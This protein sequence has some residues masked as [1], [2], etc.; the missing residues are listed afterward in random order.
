[1]EAASQM[2][3]NAAIGDVP[4]CDAIHFQSHFSF[5][6]ALRETFRKLHECEH[7]RRA[8]KFRSIAEPSLMKIKKG[9]AFV[10]GMS[11]PNAATIYSDAADTSIRFAF[12]SP[13]TT[14]DGGGTVQDPAS[15]AAGQV[16]RGATGAN[17]AFVMPFALPTLAL[18]ETVANATIFFTNANSN[19]QP[20]AT[21]LYGLGFRTSST[22][23]SGDFYAGALDTT[24][25]TLIQDTISPASIASTANG[26]ITTSAAALTN[27]IN[28]Q[29]AAGAVSGDFLFFRLNTDAL[30]DGQRLDIQL[31]NNSTV[32][33][34]PTL[35]F[36][37]VPV[38]EP[39]SA[40]LSALTLGAGL[41]VRRRN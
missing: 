12:T 39:S 26:G 34:R 2:I 17:S 19:S 30:T 25:A 7:E 15:T 35:T 10:H 36:D 28:A 13:T 23:L 18:G 11:L 3:V 4:Q 32:A 16:G 22:V 24:D 14:Q 41:L 1:M 31:G 37:I 8:G 40:L 5:F 33:K 38:P 9:L 29:I 21:D 20:Q 27:Y 6:R